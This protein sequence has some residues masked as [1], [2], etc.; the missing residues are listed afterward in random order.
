MTALKAALEKAMS[1]Q[2]RDGNNKFDEINALATSIRCRIIPDVDVYTGEVYVITIPDEALMAG[3]TANEGFRI[4]L[5][6]AEGNRFEAWMKKHNANGAS[7]LQVA[8]ENDG[9]IRFSLKR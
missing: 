8:L 3:S 5:D 9:Y 6:E 7:K 1:K 4:P 2:L